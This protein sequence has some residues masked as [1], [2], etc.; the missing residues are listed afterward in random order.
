MRKDSLNNNRKIIVGITIALALLLLIA[1]GIVALKSSGGMGQAEKEGKLRLNTLTLVR[2]YVDKEEFD[3]ALSLLEGLLIQ[4]PE[5]PDASG[6]LDAVL[7]AKR[8]KL[9]LE[10]GEEGATNAELLAALEAARQAVAR[11]ANA[12]EAAQKAASRLT[13]SEN[14]RTAERPDTAQQDS[15]SDRE[16]GQN[17]KQSQA[18]EAEAAKAEQERQQK[19]QASAEEAKRKAVENELAQ[20]NSRLQKQIA[21]VNDY[22]EQGK[23]RASSG[24]LASALSSFENAAAALPEGEKAFAAQKYTEMAEA[25]YG[26]AQAATDSTVKNEALSSALEYVN[27]AIAA[28]PLLASARYLRSRISTDQKKTESALA[29]MKEAVHLDPKNYLYAYELG[30]MQYLQKKYAEAKQSFKNLVKLSPQD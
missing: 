5:D 16:V 11:V 15:L 14:S 1:G 24:S 27:M 17:T 23:A 3:R 10:S 20:K 25:L 26:I 4:N 22:L 21:E 19:E 30:K 13:A 9:A 7:A 12:A 8:A 29:D 2:S 28:D 6:L 18:K